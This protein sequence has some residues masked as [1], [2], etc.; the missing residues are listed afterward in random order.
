MS[1]ASGT[2]SIALPV[3]A[4]RTSIGFPDRERLNRRYVRPTGRMLRFARSLTFAVGLDAFI[5]GGYGRSAA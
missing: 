5:L 4:Q 3:P 2:L 1:V